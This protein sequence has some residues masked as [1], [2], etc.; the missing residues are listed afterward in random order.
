MRVTGRILKMKTE[1][2]E[3]VIYHLPL[4]D[5]RIEM[6][7]LIGRTI[8]LNYENEIYC[9]SCGALTKRSFSQGFCY[10]CFISSSETSECI[11]RPE[12]CLAHEGKGR[13]M[14]WEKK[15]HLQ[16]HFVYLALSSDLKVG[17][18][19]STQVP[20]RWIDQG[21]S[22]A[23]CLAKTPNRFL[24]G[25]IEVSLKKHLSDKTNWQRMLK[26]EVKQGVNLS[27]EKKKV[28]E[29]LSE[30]LKQYYIEEDL[31]AEI[32]YPVIL[33]PKKVK[34]IDFEKQNLLSG[35]LNGIKGQ[36][37]IF[38]DGSVL[39]IRKHNGYVVSLEY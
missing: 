13:D 37:L 22:S 3:Q 20:T 11:L 14:E 35:K 8:S 23:I 31:I 25:C 10:T 26:N 29:L 38:E 1:L 17:V 24:S 34:S 6:N 33:Y 21:A 36:Y 19:R 39:N 7:A 28:K 18:T 9:I 2:A 15:H 32:N 4:E 16:E 27:A 12:L 30:E 5:K